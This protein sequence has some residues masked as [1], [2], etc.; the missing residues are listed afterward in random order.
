MERGLSGSWVTLCVGPSA[1]KASTRGGRPGERKRKHL[2]LAQR[3]WNTAA[4][5]VGWARA[6]VLGSCGLEVA[7]TGWSEP[8][9]NFLGAGEL[10]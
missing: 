4:T 6:G 10:G 5:D 7:F 2:V 3:V 9:L 1:E 8:P